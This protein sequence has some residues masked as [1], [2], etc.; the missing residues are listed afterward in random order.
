MKKT[1]SQWGKI[2]SKWSLG[3]LRRAVKSN[4]EARSRKRQRLKSSQLPLILSHRTMRVNQSKS[5]RLLH[6]L[7]R[8]SQNHQNRRASL[9]RLQTNHPNR[10]SRHLNLRSQRSQSLSPRKRHPWVI[11][12]N[13]GLA[14]PGSDTHNILIILEGKNEPHALA[15]LR[16]S[17]TVSEYRSF[18]NNV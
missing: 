5:R 15:D 8:R 10:K 6:P 9:V 17:K 2:F 14:S 3:S 7:L 18:S 1:Q 16:A 13:V 12:K 4:K 11:G